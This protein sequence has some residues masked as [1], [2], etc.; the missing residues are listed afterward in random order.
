MKGASLI[1]PLGVRIPDDLKEKIQDQAKA[2]G[3]SMNAEIVQ[4]LE[5]SI[6]GS[7]PQ[8]SAIYEKQIEAL[9][10]E[11]QVLKRYIEVQKRYSD[12]AE[13]QIALL[14]QHFKTATGF[15]IQEYFNKVVD[16][17]GI[18]DKHNKKPT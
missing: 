9:S 12:L 11:V 2:N 10:T 6:G 15:D 16:Y 14:K 5:E 3:R 1:A 18:E 17:K 8:I 4:I 13:E 7:G